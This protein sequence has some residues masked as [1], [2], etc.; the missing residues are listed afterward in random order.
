MDSLAPA[1]G[2]QLASIC[3]HLLQ[4]QGRLLGMAIARV[5][6]PHAASEVRIHPLRRS[7]PLRGMRPKWT[8]LDRTG[9]VVD[10]T[11]AGPEVDR[12]GLL[13]VHFQHHPESSCPSR[14]TKWTTLCFT[15]P[16]PLHLKRRR[17]L[18]ARLCLRQPRPGLP[19]LLPH[20]RRPSR[21]RHHQRSGLP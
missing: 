17:N 14:R 6:G 1:R 13:P 9:P 11:R 8:E 7:A 21:R 10:R 19:P 20:H 16:R 18:A 15:L 12:S 2:G 4:D 3:C 5:A